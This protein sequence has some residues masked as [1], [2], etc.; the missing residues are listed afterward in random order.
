MYNDIA[1]LQSFYASQLGQEVREEIAHAL[2][3][4]YPVRLDERVMGLGFSLPWL[5]EFA[6]RC[7][8]CFAMM[9]AR[10]G[11]QIWPHAESVASCLVGE[12]NLP[13]P[14]TCLDRIVLVHALEHVENAR[15]TLR[16]LWRVLVPHGEVIIIVP[17]RY[18]FWAG[19]DHTPFGNGE[20]YS[21]AQ[22]T[23]ILVQTD[24]S[25][26]SLSEHVHLWPHKDR[27]MRRFSFCF[28]TLARR[29]FPYFGGVLLAHAQ[30]QMTPA[31]AGRK[32]LQ[33]RCFV[34]SLTAQPFPAARFH[35]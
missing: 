24:F 9:P 21:R 34:P 11:A 14:D 5:D 31:I 35:I 22:L 32:R 19:A 8:R 2:A 18:G 15:A 28:E 1:S 33:K 27:E 13:L 17:N 25:L 20:P 16:E 30:R 7:E 6:S 26:Q 10:M 23:Q 3:R 12:E 29:L 4:H